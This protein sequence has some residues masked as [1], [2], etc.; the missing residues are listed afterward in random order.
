M[1]I[2]YVT[3]GDI[4]SRAANAVNIAFMCNAFNANG[5]DVSLLVPAST[6]KGYDLSHFYLHFGVSKEIEVLPIFSTRIP[7]FK[8]YI[9]LFFAALKVSGIKPDFTFVRF[10]QDY[11]YLLFAGK[12]KVI[13]ERHVPL[14]KNAWL[15]KLQIAMYSKSNM[16]LLVLITKALQDLIVEENATFAHKIRV[17]SDGANVIPTILKAKSLEGDFH[18]NI[19]YIGHLY[20]G[21]GI[22]IMI[23][24]AANNPKS[25]FHFIG[26]TE[27][28]IAR[29]KEYGHK[30]NNVFFY[31]FKPHHEVASYAIHFDVLLAPYQASVSVNGGSNTV[32]WMSPLKIF[33]YMSYNKP[34]V[35]SDLPV[36]REVLIPGKNCLLA[37]YNDIHS[38]QNALDQLSQNADLTAKIVAGARQDLENHYSWKSRAAKII[39]ELAK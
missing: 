33:E 32:N 7:I 26:G 10:I 27:Q 9:F 31:G 25:G 17:F 20:D 39:Q 4:T 2:C 6:I 19:G 36:L 14:E 21:R 11:L 28:D 15:R 18:R 24:L 22:D 1:K 35:C 37:T 38:W 8:S 29:W 34:F 3:N 5:H 23:D 12:R 16:R 30:Q 13:I